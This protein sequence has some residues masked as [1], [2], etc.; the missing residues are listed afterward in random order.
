MQFAKIVINNTR[1]V[2]DIPIIQ[3]EKVDFFNITGYFLDQHINQ[4]LSLS[5]I[6]A[7]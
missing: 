7:I 3:V 6:S 4:F 5:N 2:I 1:K